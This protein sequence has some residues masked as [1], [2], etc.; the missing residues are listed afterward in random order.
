MKQ[1]LRQKQTFSLNLTLNLQ[2]QIELLSQSGFEIRS[3]LDDLISEFCKESNNKKINYFRDEV[4][5]D[6]FRHSINPDSKGNDL[7]FYIDQENDLHEKLLE[8]L[9]ISPLKGY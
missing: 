5:L 4:L 8:Q 2:K 7:E 3:N 9:T 1:H 6:R